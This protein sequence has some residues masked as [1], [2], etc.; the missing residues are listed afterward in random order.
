MIPDVTPTN[1]AAI[2]GGVWGVDEVTEVRGA[3]RRRGVRAYRCYGALSY[4]DDELG[5]RTRFVPLP[6]ATGVTASVTPPT[7]RTP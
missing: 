1:P 5:F 7:P 4:R 3:A 6:C 2:C